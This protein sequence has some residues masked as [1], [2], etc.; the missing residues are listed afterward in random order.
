MPNSDDKPLS[1][2]GEGA[3]ASV[4]TPVDSVPKVNE[5]LETVKLSDQNEADATTVGDQDEARPPADAAVGDTNTKE[6]AELWKPHPTTEECPVCMVP[7]YLNNTKH[8]YWV[9]CGKM[10]CKACCEEHDRA[11][12]VTNMKREKKKQPPLEKT[13]AFCRSPFH[14]N[15]IELLKRYEERIGKDD[16]Q[17][18]LNLACKLMDGMNGLRKND[19]KAFSLLNRAAGLGYTGAIGMLGTCAAKGQPGSIPDMTKAKEYCEDAAKKGDAPSRHN[20][21]RL[22]ADEDNYDLAIKHWHLSAAAGCDDSIGSLWTCFYRDR[23]SKPDLEKAL[24][25]HKAASDEMKSEDRERY[26]AYKKAEAGI[27]ERLIIIYQSYYLGHTNAKELE[28]V[29]KA[30]RA[31]DWRAVHILLT[32]KARMHGYKM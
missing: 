24:R 21:A 13:C 25:A 28:K 26:D 4:S 22:L 5:Q 23:L 17:A 19:E 9:C 12:Q 31:G 6:D 11:L 3:P 8:K 16:T 27:D 14:K 10:L 1:P 2:A 30:Y 32:N 18:M 29:L 7:L 20:L 15:D